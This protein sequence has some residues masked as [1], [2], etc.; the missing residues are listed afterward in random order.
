MGVDEANSAVNQT[1]YRGI[2]GPLMY[3][4]TS[5]HDIVFSVGMCVIFQSCP[6]KSHLKEAKQILRY[7][8]K[9]EYLILFYPTGDSF[10]LVGF[11]DTDFV[12][13]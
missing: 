4:T 9:T 5:I 6:R 8:K 13:Y 12:G 3:L 11:A 1:M 10:E 2:I 7:L